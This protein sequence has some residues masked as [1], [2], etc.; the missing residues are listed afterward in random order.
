[1]IAIFI[2]KGTKYYFNVFQKGPNMIAMSKF[3]LESCHMTHV[4]MISGRI[5]R[6][7]IFDDYNHIWSILKDIEIIYR[8]IQ[9]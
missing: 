3:I 8:P 9:S 2:T 5:S 6:K 7:Q 4:T 1:M